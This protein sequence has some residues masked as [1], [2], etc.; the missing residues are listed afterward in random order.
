MKI[1]QV[2]LIKVERRKVL[3]RFSHRVKQSLNYTIQ[4]TAFTTIKTNDTF[5]LLIT[6]P[7]YTVS[8]ALYDAWA[9]NLMK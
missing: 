3:L 2:Q 5:D 1:I 9:H 8:L 4:V 6:F 7:H